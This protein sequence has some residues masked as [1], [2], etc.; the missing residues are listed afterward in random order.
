M[1]AAQ[2]TDHRSANFPGLKIWITPIT[3]HFV[4][5]RRNFVPKCY[6]F[7]SVTQHCS[8]KQGEI[9]VEP[10]QWDKGVYFNFTMTKQASRK[11][12]NHV[13]KSHYR[14]TCV[15]SANTLQFFHSGLKQNNSRYICG[16]ELLLPFHQKHWCPGV[17]ISLL[18]VHFTGMLQ[19]SHSV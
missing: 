13:V 5:L 7:C 11:Q 12:V 19:R 17:V 2:P 15:H 10:D 16:R 6:R 1:N 18:A 3:S 14:V 9:P 8:Q 4:G